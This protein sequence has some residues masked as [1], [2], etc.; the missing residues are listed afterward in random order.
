[1][2][3]AEGWRAVFIGG[4]LPAADIA[5]AVHRLGAAAV[6]L[7]IVASGPETDGAAM[8]RELRQLREAVGESVRILIGGSAAAGYADVSKAIGAERLTSL[9]ACPRLTNSS[10]SGTPTWPAPKTT[11]RVMP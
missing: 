3:A 7:S 5:A 9:T 4:D 1:M 2:A 10:A 8:E 6:G 11:E